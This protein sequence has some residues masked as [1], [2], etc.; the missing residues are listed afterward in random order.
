MHFCYIC[1]SPLLRCIDGYDCKNNNGIVN[2]NGI[3]YRHNFFIKN[4]IYT[5]NFWNN[6]DDKCYL[7][8]RKDK[9]WYC[10]NVVVLYNLILGESNSISDL[11][12]KCDLLELFS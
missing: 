3:D 6:Q 7:L 10:N 8:Q 5:A 1:Q 11:L 12:Q 4:N 9:I 2:I